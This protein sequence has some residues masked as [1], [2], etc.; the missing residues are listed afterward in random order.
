VAGVTGAAAG[1]LPEARDCVLGVMLDEHAERR[2]DDVV[3]VFDDGATWTWAQARDAVRVTA[4][5]LRTLGVREGD[6]VGMWLPNGPTAV[7]V[8]WAVNWLG[9]TL[10]PINVAYRGPLLTHVLRDSAVSLLVAHHE[11]VPRLADVTGTGLRDVVVVGGAGEATGAWAGAAG[12]TTH[13]EQVLSSGAQ[14][15]RRPVAAGPWEP[16]AV[17]YTSGTTGPSKGVK[18]SYL[19][20]FESMRAAYGYLSAEDRFLVNLP[21]F[22]VSGIGGVLTA[23]LTGGSFALV[24][25]FSTSTFWDVLRERRCTSV[26][27]MGVMATFL[28]KV[29]ARADDAANPL[30]SVLMV[31][32]A[33]D[34]KAFS[35]R[36]GCDVY[37][38]FNMTEISSP[39]VAGPQPEP[40]GTCGRVRAGIEARLVDEFDQ[41]VADGQIGELILRA[42]L[43]W[44]MT[45][46]YLN[47][48]AA[49][50]A[51]W[52]NGWFHTGDAFRRDE[53]G[54][55]FFAD[56]IKD[57]IR[58]RGENIS[59]YEL[60][61]VV[62]E[63]PA[64]REMAAVAVPSPVGEDDVLIV[65]APV[66][67]A[68]LDPGELLRFLVPR[69][70]HY[71]V[72]RY[73][74][75]VPEL[76]KTPTAKIQKHLL[77]SAGVTHDSYDRESHGVVVAR[78]RLT[79]S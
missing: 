9:A 2:P 55:Y 5:V 27:L 78:E 46:G 77:R 63:H 21:L 70:P 6:L 25:D 49:T 79:G 43:P 74:R 54:N 64:V 22:H 67:G 44:T 60:E 14:P 38:V 68:E 52:R 33:V 26:V 69:L 30:R 59:S 3:A 20:V 36:F 7:R 23:L 13:G 39:L 76:P 48:P 34:A 50:A 37:T 4:G 19:Q 1:I 58:R 42:D 35:A 16:Q 51:A 57:A 8:W 41:E 32:L 18:V 29:P 65:V 73:V 45:E 17:V 24:A 12:V 28:M 53:H 40:V 15:V 72:P 56:R 71:M 11:L 66:D 61:A 62:G 75:I 31:P 47:N 10:V